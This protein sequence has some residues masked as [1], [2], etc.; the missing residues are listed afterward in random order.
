MENQTEEKTVTLEEAVQQVI[1]DTKGVLLISLGHSEYGRMAYNLAVSLLNSAPDLK[2]H[3]VFT[4]SAIAHLNEGQ[5][6]IFSSMKEAPKEAYIRNGNVEYIKAKSMMYELSPFDTTIFLDVD[7][8]WLTKNSINEL[9]EELEGLNYTCQN[10]NN[11]EL[12]ADELDEKYSQWA[13]VKEVKEVYEF[14]E[15]KFYSLHSELIYFKKTEENKH[16]FDEW[17]NQYENLKV[18]YTDFANGIPDELPLCI[19]SII[20]N[21]YPHEDGYLP[22]YW[23]NREK[24]IER[25]ELIS[26]FYAYSIGGNRLTS[27]QVQTYND[28]VQYYMNK[29][30]SRFVFKTESKIS[31]LPERKKL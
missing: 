4:P 20:C 26:E 13:N 8:I 24:P 3:L 15:G 1:N 14:T 5:K 10:E 18:K 17:K 9:F 22:V 19:A 2:I 16:F 12:S 29:I 27:E 21:K 11:I 28:F 30:G 6:Q 25:S 31:F 7:M 23:K